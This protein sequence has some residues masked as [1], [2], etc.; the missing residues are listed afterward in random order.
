MSPPGQTDAS[1]RCD[2]T[3]TAG[4]RMLF[5][6]LLTTTVI[7]GNCIKQHYLWTALKQ[8]FITL[9]GLYF[10]TYYIFHLKEKK[11]Q[12]LFEISFNES[13][14]YKYSDIWVDNSNVCT[15]R[16]AESS[17]PS[18]DNLSQTAGLWPPFKQTRCQPEQQS[19]SACILTAHSMA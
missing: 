11:N 2:F 6:I 10:E 3:A 7:L 15:G 17:N 14:F 1:H 5:F 19:P 9:N 18:Q 16:G 4:Y 12:S 8:P 13:F